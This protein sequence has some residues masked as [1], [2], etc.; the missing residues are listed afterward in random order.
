MTE[1]SSYCCFF[2]PYDRK[3]TKHKTDCFLLISLSCFMFTVFQ[4]KSGNILVT[5]DRI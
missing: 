4:K 1:N 3:V 5:T 2:F